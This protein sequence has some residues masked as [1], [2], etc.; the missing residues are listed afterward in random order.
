MSSHPGFVLLQKV[1][2]DSNERAERM[3][4]AVQCLKVRTAVLVLLENTVEM[5][6]C[7]RDGLIS[8]ILYIH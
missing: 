2:P 5:K 6:C 7:Y 3:A 8:V 4:V 1:H